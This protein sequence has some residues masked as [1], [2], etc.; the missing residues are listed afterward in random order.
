MTAR[1]GSLEYAQARIGARHGRCA[2]D[3]LW[4]RV[5]HVRDFTGLLDLMRASPLGRWTSGLLPASDAH[6]IEATLRA[7]WREEA[8]AVTD[9]MPEPW[10]D[11]LQWFASW[12]DLVVVAHATGG[13]TRWPWLESDLVYR[14]FD[15]MRSGRSAERGGPEALLRSQAALA[16]HHDAVSAW[17]REWHRRMPRGAM[18]D[19]NVQALATTLSRERAASASGAAPGSALRRRA[20][21]ERLRTLFRAATLSPALAFVHLAL[22][23]LEVERLRGELVLRATFPAAAA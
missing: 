12:P 9:W 22:E 10:H 14:E 19:E 4:R 18:R 1:C 13:G 20:L 11:A 7:R 16:A 8:A 6:A 2:D 15:A 3:A 23:A 17:C 5:E 21:Q